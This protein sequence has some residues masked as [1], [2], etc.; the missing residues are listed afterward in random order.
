VRIDD[1]NNMR[2]SLA[3]VCLFILNGAMLAQ[4]P[5]PLPKL[6]AVTFDPYLGTY[7][8]PSGRLLVIA[9]TERRLYAY[10]PGSERIRGLERVDDRTW[11][12]GPG[13]LVYTPE[14]YRLTFLKNEK[15]DVTAVRY[16]ASGKAEEKANKAR[17]YREEQLTFRSGDVMLSGTLLIPASKGPHPAIVL[18]HGS[19]AQDRNGY[20]ANIRFMADHL[21][22]HGI[23]VLTYDKRGSGRSTGQWAT[24]SFSDLAEDLIAGIR[25]LRARSDIIPTQVGVGGSSQVGWVAAK[26]VARLPDI[27]FVM[28]I[29][30]GGSGYTV[31]EQNLYNTEVEMRAAQI[32]EERIARALDLQRRF[33]DVL[34]RG[35]GT[36]ASS[37][38]E[39]V[40]SARQDTVLADWIFPL[41]SEIDWRNRST[42]YTALEVAFDPLPAWRSYKGPVLG[43]F[44]ELDAQ[45]PVAGVVPRFTD[46]LLSRKGA[47]FTISVF[48]NA[49]HLLMEATRASDDELAQLQR[50]VP[51]F[52]DLVSEWL[53]GRLRRRTE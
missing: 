15:G 39:A 18:G 4:Q 51:G 43:V 5:A 31:E 47:D 1:I 44:G 10:E 9:R 22:R 53:W 45:T 48:A 41:S 25:T 19:G 20:V 34:R 52:Y 40:R 28:I 11:I 23:A 30:A 33:F 8:L 35:E 38:D 32:S 14:N 46:A 37:Y 50:M 29:S 7:E 26:A 13:L 17:L 2:R 42:W 3:F 21:A 12:A 16:A 24:A 27:A 36:D 49:S 6:D